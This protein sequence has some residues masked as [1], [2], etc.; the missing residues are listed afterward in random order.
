MLAILEQ[1]A[2]L[3]LLIMIG[4]AATRFGVLS[5]NAVQ[6]INRLIIW[7]CFPALLIANMDKTFTIEMLHS[8]LALLLISAG[9]YTA[10]IIG[11]EI[12]RRFSKAPA[13]Q[14]GL[15]QFLILM[16]NTAFMGFPVINAIY[17]QDGIFYASM[18]NIWHNFVCYSYGFY[19]L[20]RQKKPK[21]LK[22]LANPAFIA[23]IAGFI[24]FLL[25]FTL[26]Y[27]LHYPLE[28]VGNMTIPLS[29]FVVGYQFAHIKPKELLRP[30][31]LWFISFIRLIV[32]PCILLPVLY[33][34]GLRGTL[35]VVPVIIFATP[36][37]LTAG[38][39]AKEYGH[40]EVLGSKAVLLSN[41][42]SVITLPLLSIIL[43]QIG[44]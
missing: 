5:Q 36:V 18:F 29:L 23:T 13:K 8:S 26:P 12:W 20:H 22:I 11:L 42:L 6:G 35:L 19:L 24:L 40:D 4:A 1:I 27:V 38:T 15:V 32:F 31:T 9:C 17:G 7:V 44:L 28:W 39:F 41:F 14:L 16:G 2:I 33:A 25:P 10:L 21:L 30:K 34:I 43:A 3:L 37:A